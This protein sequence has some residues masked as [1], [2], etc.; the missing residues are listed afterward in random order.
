MTAI[1]KVRPDKLQVDCLLRAFT[2]E[3]RDYVPSRSVEI[4]GVVTEPSLSREDFIKYGVGRL[5]TPDFV[6]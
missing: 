5:K 2:D 1:Q 3:Y 6:M 4:D